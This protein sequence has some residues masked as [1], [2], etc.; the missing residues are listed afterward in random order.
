MN[1]IVADVNVIGHLDRIRD[2]ISARGWQSYWDSLGLSVVTFADLGLASDAPDD[3]VWRATQVAGVVLLTSNR[4][5]DGPDSLEATMRDEGQD[6]SLPV[7]TIG[8]AERLLAS[9]EYAERVMVRLLEILTDVDAVR[10]AGR[11][12]IP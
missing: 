11:I 8:D 2:F 12:Y 6:D 7:L 10:G 3:E 9:T 5:N 1:G 4:N